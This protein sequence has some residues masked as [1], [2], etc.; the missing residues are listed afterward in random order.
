MTDACKDPEWRLAAE[1]LRQA[2]DDARAQSGQSYLTLWDIQEA[3]RFCLDPQGVW[4]EARAAWCD[5]ASVTPEAFHLIAQRSVG[6]P[7][8]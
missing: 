1:V 6:G 7:A 5:A 4:A 8:A 2:M 3:R